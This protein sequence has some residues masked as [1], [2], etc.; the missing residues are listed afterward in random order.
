MPTPP[1][2]CRPG[3]P[4]PAELSISGRDPATG[5]P[6]SVRVAGGVITAVG[7][8]PPDETRWLAPGLV[9]LQVNGF[10]GHDL[11]AAGLTV[12]TVVALTESLRARGTT[13][14]VP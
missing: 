9:D 10:G 4:R 7:A 1:A 6:I 8:G 5:S 3:R 12:D 2:R 13:T 11:N 14:Y